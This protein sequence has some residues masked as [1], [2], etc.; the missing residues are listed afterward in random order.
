MQRQEL[1]FPV[2]MA[3]AKGPMH[4]NSLRF[5]LGEYG[6][7]AM[8]ASDFCRLLMEMVQH[9]I[10]EAAIAGASDMTFDDVELKDAQWGKD[11]DKVEFNRVYLYVR[12]KQWN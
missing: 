4:E 1:A 11:L 6:M 3:L 8:M 2:M 12:L 9:G 5:S 7:T 10:L